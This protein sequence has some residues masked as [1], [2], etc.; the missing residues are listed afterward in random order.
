MDMA[1][2]YKTGGRQKG[3]LNKRTLARNPFG[4]LFCVARPHMPLM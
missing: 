2:G 4:P 3:L 1:A